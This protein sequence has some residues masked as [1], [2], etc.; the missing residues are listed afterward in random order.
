MCKA[1]KDKLDQYQTFQTKTAYSI[2]LSNNI[3]VDSFVATDTI[4]VK[5]AVYFMR[6]LHKLYYVE[7]RG[8]MLLNSV[9]KSS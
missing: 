8:T 9:S 4:E 3:N 5:N 7:N 1:C 2:V 6:C